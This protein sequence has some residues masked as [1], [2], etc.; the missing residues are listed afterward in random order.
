M[1]LAIQF[2]LKD[3]IVYNVHNEYQMSL[4]HSRPQNNLGIAFM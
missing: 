2:H 3:C 4:K 1:S